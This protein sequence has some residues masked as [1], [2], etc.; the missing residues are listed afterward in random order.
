MIVDI[1][2]GF[3]RDKLFMVIQGSELEDAVYSR[4]PHRILG[5][6]G[7]FFADKKRN[8]TM[9][10]DYVF[11]ETIAD[12]A[13]IILENIP[14]VSDYTLLILSH[15]IGAT[16]KGI[17][18]EV[19]NLRQRCASTIMFNVNKMDDP[20]KKSLALVAASS[21][22]PDG[23]E[24]KYRAMSGI[25]DASLVIEDPRI[26]YMNLNLAARYLGGNYLFNG[27]QGY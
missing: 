15:L 23:S 13:D 21:V 19:I 2:D 27:Y 26:K 1:T 14:Q 4:D 5:S 16:I 17:P 9:K 24:W 7:L 6:M 12:G 18:D 25:V 8:A 3:N 22:Y 20:L 10:L 11:C